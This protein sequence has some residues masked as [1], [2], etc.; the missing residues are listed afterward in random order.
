MKTRAMK[1]HTVLALLKQIQFA[2]GLM[3]RPEIFSSPFTGEEKKL[4]TTLRL[5][6]AT[7]NT[8]ADQRVVVTLDL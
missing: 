2:S 5:D 1:T 3:S 6:E 8:F 7:F 4:C